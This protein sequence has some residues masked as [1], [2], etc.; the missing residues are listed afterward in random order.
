MN[1]LLLGGSGDI[2]DAIFKEIY[3]PDNLYYLTYSKNKPKYKATNVKFLKL[4]FYKNFQ[5]NKNRILKKIPFNLI[6]NNVGDCNPYK[7]VE[8]LTQ[9]ELIKSLKINFITPL[10]I[11]LEIVK[12]NVKNKVATKIINISS[13]TIKF[14]GSKKNFQYFISK[15]S[16]ENSLLYISRH[17]AKNN[18]KVNIIRPGLISTNKTTKLKNYSNKKFQER[19]K[20]IPMRKAGEP[21]DIAK[22]VLYLSS[23][24]SDFVSGQ[25]I[26]VSGGE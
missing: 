25:I 7:D 23:K 13:N 3:K 19:E 17:F 2:G 26:S 22:L 5:F 4:N 20:L 15:S 8:K 1:I 16:L 11:I 21:K 6:I 12:K 9:K 18:I 10:N 24:D 14:L